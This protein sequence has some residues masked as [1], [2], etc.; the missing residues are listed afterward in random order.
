M[1][2]TPSKDYKRRE[3]EQRKLDKRMAREAAKIQ[4]LEDQQ[5][6]AQAAAEAAVKQDAADLQA[7]LEAD[8]EAELEAER[9]SQKVA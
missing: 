6:A 8:F 7:K 3:R 4:E 2:V 1:A 5:V 9:K